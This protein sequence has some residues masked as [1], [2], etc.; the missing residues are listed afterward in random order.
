MSNH[1][2]GLWGYHGETRHGRELTIQST[3]IGGPSAAGCCGIAHLGVRRAVR[4][5]TGA[6][7]AG[8]VVECEAVVVEGALAR[9]EPAP[10]SVQQGWSPPIARSPTGS[11][12]P[13]VKRRAA[14]RWPASISSKTVSRP[15]PTW[16]VSTSRLQRCWRSARGSADDQGDRPRRRRRGSGAWEDR[17][18]GA[19]GGAGPLAGPR[20]R[21]F[22]IGGV[23]SQLPASPLS[24]ND[25]SSSRSSTSSSLSETLRSPLE[26]LDVVRGGDVERRHRRALPEA[27]SPAPS[28]ATRAWLNS[29]LSSRFWVN[30]PNAS[31]PAL[32]SRSRMLSS[33]PFLAQLDSSFSA[34]AACGRA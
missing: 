16:S 34:A 10:R 30:S 11:R 6:A 20:S 12:R 27:P 5:G 28:A 7:P 33:P 23:P 13:R 24:S 14:G 19:S 21:G 15:A 4:V 32:D 17:A 22:L 18:R 2:H 9:M 29:G 31:S 1:N 8:A 3:G 25:S 26:P